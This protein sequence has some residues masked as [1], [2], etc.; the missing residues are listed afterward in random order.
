MPHPADLIGMG[1]TPS[2]RPNRVRTVALAVA[3]SA[4]CAGGFAALGEYQATPGGAAPAADWPAGSRVPRATVGDTLVLVIHPQCPCSRAT[5]DNLAVLMAHCPAGRVAAVAVFVR[6]AGMPAGWERTDLWTSAEA[7]P[8]VTVAADPGGVEA[9]RF[10]AATSGQAL[11]FDPAGRLLFG[12]GLT[13]GRGHAGDCGGTDAVLA[14]VRGDRPTAA[15]TPVFGCPLTG[16]T[17]RGR[18]TP[19]RGASR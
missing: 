17:A 3:W 4:A 11:L 13:P 12:G 1:A 6:P 16:P 7:I 8:G 9:A 18:C 10:G 15:P 2:I 14:I 19:A 5:I